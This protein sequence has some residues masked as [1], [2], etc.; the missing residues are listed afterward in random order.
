MPEDVSNQD[1]DLADVECIY[2]DL[3]GWDG[4]LS[5]IRDFGD[6]PKTAQ[7]YVRTIE[8]AVKIPITIMGVGPKRSEVIFRG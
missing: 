6:L 1:F 8:D 5:Q 2:E 7:D 3:P 4:D